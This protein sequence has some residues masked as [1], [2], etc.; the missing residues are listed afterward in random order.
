MNNRQA[1]VIR[2]LKIDLRRDLYEGSNGGK[3]GNGEFW[4]TYSADEQYAPLTHEDIAEL[5]KA[6]VIRRK[7]PDCDGCFILTMPNVELSGREE[8]S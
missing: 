5:L 8:K 4:V 2:L 1:A 6:R 7:W 3:H